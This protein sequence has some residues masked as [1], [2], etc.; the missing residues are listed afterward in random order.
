MRH[1][2]IQFREELL[3]GPTYLHN[4]EP[5]PTID[6]GEPEEVDAHQ[7]ALTLAGDGLRAVITWIVEGR[8]ARSQT[9]RLNVVSHMLG[10]Q[11]RASIRQMAREL[12]AAPDTVGIQLARLAERFPAL[13]TGTKGAGRLDAVRR[14]MRK[15]QEKQV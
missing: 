5:Q 3:T 2:E 8:T 12:G 7:E 10:I 6:L 14:A 9:I 4:G 11:R 13:K 1:N 15:H